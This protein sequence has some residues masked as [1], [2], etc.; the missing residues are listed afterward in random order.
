MAMVDRRPGGGPMPDVRW[1][2]GVALSLASWSCRPTCAEDEL[3]WGDKCAK[4][5]DAGA[6]IGTT[7]PIDTET[8]PSDGVAHDGGDFR[9]LDGT[10]DSGTVLSCTQGSSRCLEATG[11]KRETCSDGEW[12]QAEPCNSE[13]RCE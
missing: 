6:D 8:G 11:S 13:Q 5:T 12:V 9:A 2:V 7:E 3:R 1:C 4:R 10:S